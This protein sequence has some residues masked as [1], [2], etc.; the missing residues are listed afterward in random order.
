MVNACLMSKQLNENI[1]TL[2]IQFRNPIETS[3][4]LHVIFSN[5]PLIWIFKLTKLTI[6]QNLFRWGK[7]SFPLTGY[8]E[9]DG[10]SVTRPPSLERLSVPD[11]NYISVNLY[12]NRIC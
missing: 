1:L 5:L 2:R 6:F 9:P 8:S 7:G 4:C 11:R 3:H 10:Q 12:R